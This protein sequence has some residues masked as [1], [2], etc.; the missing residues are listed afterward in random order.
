M[1]WYLNIVLVHIFLITNEDKQLFL[2]IDD[3]CFL[4]CE[5]PAYA[6]IFQLA[7][8]PDLKEFIFSRYSSTLVPVMFIASQL[9]IQLSVPALL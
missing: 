9:Q 8:F 4:F 5:I 6:F 1:R 3:L 7:C 2:F